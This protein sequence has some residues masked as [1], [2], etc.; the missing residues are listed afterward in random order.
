MSPKNNITHSEY[1]ALAGFRYALRQF[2]HF[3]EEVAR[4]AGLTPQQYQAMLAIKGFPGTRP[5]M[6]GELAE[7]LQVRHHSAVG[8][9]GRLVSHGLVRREVPD[10]DRRQVRL[11]LTARGEKMLRGLSSAHKEQL[12]RFGPQLAS[13][14]KELRG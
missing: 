12:R 14:L 2:L 10:A 13:L 8:L 1:E 7:R 4:S 9:V 5:M 3:S 11:S 6:I